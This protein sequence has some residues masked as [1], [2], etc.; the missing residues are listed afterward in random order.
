MIRKSFLLHL[1]VVALLFSGFSQSAYAGF[2]S[3]ERA[4]ALAT[5]QALVTDVQAKLASAQV[6]AALKRLGVSDQQIM[7]RVAAMTETELVTLSEQLE[8]MPA[9]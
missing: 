6:Q 7:A 5:H 1:S 2:I 9:G 4:A 3:S 8:Q